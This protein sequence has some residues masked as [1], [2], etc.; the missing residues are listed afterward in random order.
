MVVPLLSST[1]ADRPKLE[2]ETSLGSS[3]FFIEKYLHINLS[4]TPLS[5]ALLRN[6]HYIGK[7]CGLGHRVP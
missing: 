3:W 6:V 4:W 1:G 5:P 2:D 7:L